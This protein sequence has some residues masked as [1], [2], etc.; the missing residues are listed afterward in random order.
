MG[1]E[2]G[3]RKRAASLPTFCLIPA[4]NFIKISPVLL[5]TLTG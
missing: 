4:P 3:Y 5:S 2:S 1:S